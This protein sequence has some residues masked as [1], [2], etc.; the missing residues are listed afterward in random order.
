[1][2]IMALLNTWLM[3]CLHMFC[4]SF[5]NRTLLLHDVWYYIWFRPILNH[6]FIFYHINSRYCLFDYR[7]VDFRVWWVCWFCPGTGF[8]NCNQ[9]FDCDDG[10][11]S[12]YLVRWSSWMANK[13][14]VNYLA[15]IL[16]YFI[17]K[18]GLLR[19]IRFWSNADIYGFDCIDCFPLWFPMVWFAF[20]IFAD[21]LI[22]RFGYGFSWNIILFIT[23]VMEFFDSWL[24]YG[25]ICVSRSYTLFDLIFWYSN[26]YLPCTL[27]PC[28]KFSHRVFIWQGFLTRQGV[29]MIDVFGDSSFSRSEFQAMQTWMLHLAILS[30][31]V[32]LKIIPFPG[33]R[34][35]RPDAEVYKT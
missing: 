29:W 16:V 11:G 17:P 7:P 20:W 18:E 28:S 35:L 15:W 9:I 23:M 25:V 12:V 27:F 34:V 1:M 22:V 33:K 2:M 6:C 30:G 3:L 14:S 4:F 13:N 8:W 5:M 19:T 32:M 26:A 21:F 24:G 10:D 31:V